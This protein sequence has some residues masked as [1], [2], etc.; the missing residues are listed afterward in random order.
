MNSSTELFQPHDIVSENPSPQGPQDVLIYHVAD[1]LELFRI[2]TSKKVKSVKCLKAENS[3][4]LYPQIPD[5]VTLCT[6]RELSLEFSGGFAIVF[7]RT[8][9]N[10]YYVPGSPFFSESLHLG[11]KKGGLELSQC[12]RIECLSSDFRI[13]HP[14]LSDKDLHEYARTRNPL[15]FS[16]FSIELPSVTEAYSGFDAEKYQIE[17]AQIIKQHLIDNAAELLSGVKHDIDLG[18]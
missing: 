13:A 12:E 6:E 10:N 2:L 3:L 15:A 17:S 11:G 8:K 18:K 14:Q 4:T 5:G 1:P 7:D 9:I 16:E